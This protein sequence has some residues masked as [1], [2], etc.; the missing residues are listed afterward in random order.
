[1]RKRQQKRDAARK[2][3]E[4]RMGAIVEQT[5]GPDR[6][7]RIDEVLAGRTRELIVVVENLQD[8]HNL[9]AVLRSAEGFGVQEVHVVET[10]GALEIAPKVTQGCHKWLD[11]LRHPDARSCV[12]HLHG[13]GFELWAATLGPDTISLTD[14][15]FGRRVALVLG[16]ESLGLTPELIDLCDGSYRIPMRGFVQSFNISV[17]AAV[18]IF[19]ATLPG[20][21]HGGGVPIGLPEAD[22]AD[23]RQRWME[24]SVKQVARIGDAVRRDVGLPPAASASEVSAHD[25]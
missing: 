2:E 10:E 17:A 19:Y 1:M 21:V 24:Q 14:I 3:F 4:Q 8:R 13:R 16:N 25:Q 5:V 15:D 11:V 23:L 22:H 6:R 9:S 7:E 20:D 12:D 18:S